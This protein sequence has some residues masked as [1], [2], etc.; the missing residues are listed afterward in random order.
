M[1]FENSDSS[2]IDFNME[3]PH[4]SFPV[5]IQ[6]PFVRHGFSTR[7][8]GVSEGFFSSMNFGVDTSPYQD[9]PE[10][11]KENYKRIAK[12]IGVDPNSFV[13]S[14]QVHK[15]HIRVVEEKDLGKGVTVPADYSEIDGLITNKPG[16]T[17]VTKYADCVPLYFV[18]PKKKAI[19]LSHSGWRGTVK[20]I[21]KIT[22]EEM[23]KAYGSNPEDIFTV[24]GPS[25]CK[26]CYEIGAEVAEEFL[27]AFPDA[28]EKGIL[29]NKDN[30]KFQCD[31]WAANRE[32]M[33]EA[34]LK[35]DNIHISNVCTCCNSDWLF[36]HRI[37]GFQRGS[38]AAF[39][40]I[41]E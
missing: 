36:S 13:V 3:V 26:D 31:L 37:T 15:T 4:I 40:A 34:G 7:L 19:G 35:G 8:G 12:S 14:K 17:L 30:G 23:Q 29:K 10:N 32:V 22:V 16:I 2:Q 28:Y 18:D 25:I 9:D 11:I 21:G 33:L 24:I 39:L 1:K 5:L 20:K 6:I 27:M 41:T 38:L